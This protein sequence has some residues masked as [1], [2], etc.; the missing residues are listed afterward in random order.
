ML[1]RA[2][3]ASAAFLPLAA[4][5]PTLQHAYRP[6]AGFGGPRLEADSFVSFDGA[7]LGLTVWPAQGG[8]PTA[9]IVALH[10]MN[11]YSAAFGLAAEAWARLGITTYAYDQRGYGRSPNR[12]VWPSEDLIISDLRAMTALVRA[13]HPE[14]TLAVAGVSMGGAAAMAA[15]SSDSPPDADRVILLAP[16]VWGWSTQYLPNATALWLS[17]RTAPDWVVEPPKFIVKRIKVTDNLEE[18]RR[19]SRDPLMLWGARA[20]ALYGIVTLMQRAFDGAAAIK[21]PALYLYGFRDE[22][23]PK[24]PS[25]IAAGRLKTTDQT[26]YY[27]DGYHLLLSDLQAWR[28]YA[29]VAGFIR[30]A[31]APLVSGVGPIPQR[32]G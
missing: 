27:R 6:G 5:A 2:F 26:G 15:F 10:G 12:G 31:Q 30:D 17:T 24:T 21:V 18:M 7:R 22:V 1:R 23:I 14:A 32:Q 4:C 29:D 19:M 3:L 25:F 16:A 13:R 9:V 11:D 20:D 8:E 28:V